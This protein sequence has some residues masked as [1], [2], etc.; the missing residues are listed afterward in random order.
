MATS[1]FD[2]DAFTEAAREQWQNVASGWHQWID[3]IAGLLAD[4]TEQMLD[5]AQ[6]HQG[7]RVLDLAAGDGEQSIRAAHRV[8]ADGYVLATDISPKLLT[9]AEESAQKLGLGQLETQ[10]M[11]ART[12]DAADE[13]FD[14]VISRLGLM[15]IPEPDRVFAEIRRVLR[16][17]GRVSA[18]VFST[19]DKSPWLSSP[20]QVAMRH[21]GRAP[22]APG[23]PGLFSLGAPG[24]VETALRNAGFCDV[25]VN[26]STS[27]L[28]MESAHQCI[29][30]IHEIGGAYH[31]V[32]SDLDEN[33]REQAWSA[34]EESL[35]LL[36]R[37]DRF[38]SPCEV[39]VGVG[40]K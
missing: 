40:M 30:M 38:R 37:A 8:G 12:L 2:P 1:D 24:A 15:L 14:A 13:S 32:L 16:P 23:Q 25:E 19:P 7:D 22:S 18:I 31:A 5:L 17:G 36:E 20:M 11:D 6:V 35:R 28:E 34:M 27:I 3:V 9:F 21:A 26:Y 33:A 39:I 29:T 10:V 4:A